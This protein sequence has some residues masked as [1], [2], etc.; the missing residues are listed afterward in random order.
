MASKRLKRHSQKSC[1]RR[2]TSR[3][4]PVM[5]LGKLGKFVMSHRTTKDNKPYDVDAF[6]KPTNPTNKD[7]DND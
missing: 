2:R 6:I 1:A 3:W 7:G 4:A 5:P